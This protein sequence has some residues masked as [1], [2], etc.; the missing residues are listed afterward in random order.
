[1]LNVKLN[2]KYRLIGYDEKNYVI[3]E[4]KKRVNGKN[5]GDVF[6]NNIGYYGEIQ[7]AINRIIELKILKSDLTDLKDIKEFICKTS[8]DITNNI[9]SKKLEEV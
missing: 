4:K 5:A 6:W 7:Q 8:V 1:M 9:N 3:Q 2:E